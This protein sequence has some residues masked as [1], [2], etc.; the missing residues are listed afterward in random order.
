[1]KKLLLVLAIFATPAP[2]LAEETAFAEESLLAFEWVL[3]ITALIGPETFYRIPGF[4]TQGNCNTAGN[5]W[6]HSLTV[7]VNQGGT[8]VPASGEEILTAARNFKFACMEV[9]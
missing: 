4:S 6:R 2:A 1:M 3:Q 7:T 9:N 8:I 5:A